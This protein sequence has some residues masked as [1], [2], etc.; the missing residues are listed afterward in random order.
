[1]G[2]SNSHWKE[3]SI[4]FNIF[5][6]SP[7]KFDFFGSPHKVTLP[8]M[9]I[10]LLKFP[11]LMQIETITC[12]S[13]KQV[14]KSLISLM[15]GS[16]KGSICE[17]QGCADFRE[18]VEFWHISLS[19]QPIFSLSIVSEKKHYSWHKITLFHDIRVKKD[20]CEFIYN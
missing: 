12:I 13:G 5:K 18:N 20:H 2:I 11:F 15:Q 1:M 9:Q 19:I 3:I 14:I 17:K 4:F 10:Y 8:L 16:E 7:L 6:I